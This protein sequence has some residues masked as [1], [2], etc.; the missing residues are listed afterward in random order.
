MSAVM[1]NSLLPLNTHDCRTGADHIEFA[2]RSTAQVD[3]ATTAIR[4]AIHYAHNNR[5]AVVMVG[6]EHPGAKRQGAVRRSKPDARGPLPV[7]IR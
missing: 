1:V 2:C 3:N 4:P 5:L 7:E 6:D